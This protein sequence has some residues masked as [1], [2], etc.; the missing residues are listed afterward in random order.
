MLYDEVPEVGI[1]IEEKIKTNEGGKDEGESG[2]VFD[3][4]VVFAWIVRYLY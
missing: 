1:P 2:Q 4:I 3:R